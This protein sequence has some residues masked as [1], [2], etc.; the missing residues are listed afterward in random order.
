MED[1]LHIGDT[2]KICYFEGKIFGY[3]THN[4]DKLVSNYVMVRAAARV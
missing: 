1:G 3:M 4:T 2:K